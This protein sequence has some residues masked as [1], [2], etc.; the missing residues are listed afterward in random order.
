MYAC[1]MCN[2]LFKNAGGLGSHQKASEKKGSCIPAPVVVAESIP[3]PVVVAESLPAPIVVA[4][5]LPAPVVVE[6]PEEFYNGLVEIIKD[7]SVEVSEV[8]DII[9]GKK[10][11]TKTPAQKKKTKALKVQSELDGKFLA[12]GFQKEYDH[13]GAFVQYSRTLPEKIQKTFK[14]ILEKIVYDDIFDNLK[15]TTGVDHSQGNTDTYSL[16]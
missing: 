10:S 16:I 3:A 14:E 1:T 9:C 15:N 2:R 8:P 13:S 7:H 5:S 6:E 4:E 12:S 11:Q